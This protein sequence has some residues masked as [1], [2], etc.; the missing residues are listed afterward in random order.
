[1]AI[2]IRVLNQLQQERIK[3]T[4]FKTADWNGDLY[5]PGFMYDAADIEDW[6]SDKDYNLGDV[7]I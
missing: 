2:Y 7:V 5:A 3:L 4:G 6:V 1:M